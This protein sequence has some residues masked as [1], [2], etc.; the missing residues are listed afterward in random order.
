MTS[1]RRVVAPAGIVAGELDH[2]GRS[3]WRLWRSTR[4]TPCAA[5]VLLGQQPSV[6]AQDRVRR[7]DAGELLQQLASEELPLGREAAALFIGE[8]DASTAELPVELLAQDAILL[9]QIRDDVLLSAIHEPGE[10][11][12]KEVQCSG[13]QHR[14]TTSPT[15]CARATSTCQALGARLAEGRVAAENG[16]GQVSRHNDVTS[17]GSCENCR[18]S[19]SGCRGLRAGLPAPSTG[20][21]SGH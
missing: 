15:G 6:P 3:L 17:T 1:R 16:M 7:D 13:R 11:Q 5:V 14:T 19:R 20:R 8:A 12:E 21:T 18:S 2:Q 9:D 10:G 4:P